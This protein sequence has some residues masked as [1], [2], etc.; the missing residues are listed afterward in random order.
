MTSDQLAMLAAFFKNG[1]VVVMGDVNITINNV[2]AYNAYVGNHNAEEAYL[3]RRPSGLMIAK[4]YE[5]SV[6]EDHPDDPWAH[7]S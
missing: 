1:G 6:D 2:E 5:R 7:I 4:S 3:P